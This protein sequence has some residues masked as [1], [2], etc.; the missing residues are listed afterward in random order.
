MTREEA[1]E[2]TAPAPGIWL[3][4]C[5]FGTDDREWLEGHLWEFPGHSERPARG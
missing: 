5:G 3:C 2:L 4:S 1:E